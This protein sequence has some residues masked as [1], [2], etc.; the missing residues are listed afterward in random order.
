[1]TM[2]MQQLLM[3]AG[4][5]VLMLIGSAG[6]E[7][8]GHSRGHGIGLLNHASHAPNSAKTSQTGS[9]NAAAIMQTGAG[10]VA[11]IRQRGDDNQAELVQTGDG[12]RGRIVQVGDGLSAAA[13]QEGGERYN[14]IQVN[15][16]NASVDIRTGQGRRKAR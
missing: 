1:M 12:N 4:A 5:A 7:A 8:G 16:G 11:R 14:I 10:N 6:A 15:K 9:R 13:H 3:A 2:T